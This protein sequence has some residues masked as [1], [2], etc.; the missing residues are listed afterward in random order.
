VL[1]E[2][3]RLDKPR[4]VYMIKIPAEAWIAFLDVHYD[5]VPEV[6]TYLAA[7][8]KEQ[9]INPA[10]GALLEA[11]DNTIDLTEEEIEGLIESVKRA[12]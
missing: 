9:E 6:A 2:V 4:P 12:Q 10:K 8:E 1:K 11:I 5:Y 3:K 7:V